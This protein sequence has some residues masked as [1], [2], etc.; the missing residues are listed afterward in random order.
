[1]KQQSSI[2]TAR[3]TLMECDDSRS[4]NR[5][6]SA[7]EMIL[8]SGYLGALESGNRKCDSAACTA[9]VFRAPW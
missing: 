8:R 6:C 7:C 4:F 3:T 2:L 1:M 9:P 5:C